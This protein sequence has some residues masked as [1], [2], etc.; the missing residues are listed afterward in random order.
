MD[1]EKILQ[2]VEDGFSGLKDFQSASVE[3][4]HDSL[5]V[6]QHKC[7]LLADEVGLGKTIIARGLIAKIIR[8][9][10]AAG[11]T[12]PLKVTYICSNQVIA[13]EN[14]R[15]LN[16][17][18]KSVE[19]KE[20]ISR[21][22]YLAWEATKKTK[23]ERQNVLEL[24]TLTPAT[25]FRFASGVGNVWER[26]IIYALLSRDSIMSQH[27]EG[28][29]WLLKGTVTRSDYNK[30]MEDARIGDTYHTL[31]AGL[32]ERYIDRIKGIQYQPAADTTLPESNPQSLYDATLS[33]ANIIHGE[34]AKSHQKTCNN[35]SRKLRE[36]LV[37]CCLPYVDA[38]LFIL[39]EFQRFRDLIDE[40]SQEEQALIAK[41]VF[42][43]Q[44]NDARILLLSATPFK[45]FTGHSDIERGEDHYK[46]FNRVLKFLLR[47]DN[48][49]LAQYDIHRQQLHRQLLDIGNGKT[50][51][52][53]SQHRESVES[54]LRPIICRTERQSVTTHANSMVTDKWKD[55]EHAIPF[56]LGDIENFKSTDRVAKAL[57]R[58]SSTNGKPIEYCKSALYPLS[59]LDRYKLKEELKKYKDH[60][61]VSHALDQSAAAWVDFKRIDRYEDLS[62]KISKRSSAPS[63]ARLEHLMD[64]AIGTHGEKLLWVPPSLPY[65]TLEDAYTGSEG[66]SKTLLFSSWVMVPRMASTLVSY[67]VERRTIGNARTIDEQEVE[68]RC[69]FT[70]ERKRRHPVPQIRYARRKSPHGEIQLA[71]MSNYTLL[72]PSQALASII[73]PIQNLSNQRSLDELRKQVADKLR[74]QLQNPEITQYITSGGEGDRWYWAAPLLLDKVSAQFSKIVS[75]WFNSTETSGTAA[76]GESTEEDDD[77]AKQDHFEHFKNCFVDPV[78][79]ELGRMP[80]DLPEVLA[81]LA[82]GSPAVITLRSINRLFSTTTLTEPKQLQ[83]ASD[84]ADEFCSLFNK[85]ESI[86]AVR[87][88]EK[89]QW[90]WQMIAD[91][92]ASG[93]L[94]SV[95]DEYFHLLQGQNADNQGAVDQLISAINLNA[96]TINVDSLETFQNGTPKKMRCHYAV[97]FGSQRIETD[98]GQKRASGLREVFN[99]PF[100]P[101]LLSTTSIGQ[102]GLDFH[103]YC[104]RIVHW[105][106]PNNPVDLEQREGR[107]NRFK[108][109]AIRQQLA[110]KYAA[111]LAD[112]QHD[113][114]NDIWDN[115]FKVADI[116][117]RQS[118]GKCELVPFW[119]IDSTSARKIERVIP[120]YPYSQDQV[121]LSALLKTLAIYR[122]AFGQPRQAELVDHLLSNEF[123]EEQI[124]EIMDRLMVNLSPILYQN[125]QQQN[126]QTIVEDLDPM[127]LEDAITT[128]ALRFMGYEYW[129]ERHHAF[130]GAHSGDFSALTTDLIKTGTLHDN[131]NDNLGA[132]FILQRYLCKWG[133][134]QLKE[135]SPERIVYYRLFLHCYKLEIPDAFQH[136]DY[137]NKWTQSSPTKHEAIAD[138]IRQQKSVTST[139]H[140]ED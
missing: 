31:K 24:N 100:R 66:F 69:Y 51:N 10:I 26:R 64:Q 113:C 76:D 75:Q 60:P 102:E 101:F 9:R 82:L 130:E 98:Q 131:D 18:P 86:A 36:N 125:K 58:V 39:D 90:Y 47:S 1:S 12:R 110:E 33:L 38:D 96:S 74:E 37:E 106:L 57:A 13:N 34:N 123:S 27:L 88:S 43:E 15:K 129:D 23:K 89:H 7:M 93:C 6:K 67:E 52:L 63:N 81:D 61:V 140:H 117:E 97:E 41:K 56:S 124:A 109:L 54:I 70:E 5:Y 62:P 2:Y 72:Y 118:T 4:I 134:E 121:R 68:R 35:I 40:D 120:L 71:N 16:L 73:D 20:P 22:A 48:E 87:L 127:E 59:Y 114:S 111:N 119:H 139:G 17:F 83:R 65:Y 84:V 32:T 30:W 45:A 105:N 115:L 122:L 3:T 91:Y 99:S 78:S 95:L 136:S 108:S 25:S 137:H 21:I 103:S 50:D 92:C 28:I 46:D 132:F 44:G 133:G 79:A 135:D 112:C 11:D 14:I 8:D 55:A 94:Q 138:Q 128:C 77:G 29:K 107:I 85:P 104:R 53:S 49:K 80:E 116:E 126:Q 42:F 19:M